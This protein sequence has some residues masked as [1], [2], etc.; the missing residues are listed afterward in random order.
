MLAKIDPNNF[1]N[2]PLKKLSVIKKYAMTITTKQNRSPNSGIIQKPNGEWRYLTER[3]CWRLQ[4]YTDEDF[5]N[6]ARVNPGKEG[7]MNSALY[8]QAGNSIPV[9]IFESIF[10]KI[11]LNQTDSSKKE[12]RLF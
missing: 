6:A 4:G 5:D 11:I 7:C 3:E 9:P 10:R 1:D 12:N 8:K 2:A